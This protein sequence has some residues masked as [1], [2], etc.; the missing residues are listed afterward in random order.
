MEVKL[1]SKVDASDLDKALTF[2]ATEIREAVNKQIAELRKEVPGNCNATELLKIK[3]AKQQVT[4]DLR[5]SITH[6]GT[7]LD[8]YGKRKMREIAQWMGINKKWAELV[9]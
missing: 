3:T 9:S 8:D 7:R 5:S 4:N 1:A 2:I 6:L